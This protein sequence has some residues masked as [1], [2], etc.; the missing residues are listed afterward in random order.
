[1]T[2]DNT[3]GSRIFLV[4]AVTVVAL[5]GLLGFFVGSN[6]AAVAP[7]I[8]VAGGLTLPTTPLTMTAYGMLLAAVSLAALFGL[9]SF[10]SRFDE[11]D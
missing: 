7:T 6:G 4:V 3:D 11:V 8:S 9:V 10:A 1:V 5:A 2:N